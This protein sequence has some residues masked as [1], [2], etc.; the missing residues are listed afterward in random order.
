MSKR[1]D[2]PDMLR[3]AR[4]IHERRVIPSCMTCANFDEQKE[5]CDA[6]HPPRRPPARVIAYGCPSWEDEALIRYI[7]GT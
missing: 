4:K 1:Y 2:V 5:V 3:L 6:V 7:T